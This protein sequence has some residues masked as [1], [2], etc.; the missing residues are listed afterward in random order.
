M[1]EQIFFVDSDPNHSGIHVSRPLR[2]V[3]ALLALMLLVFILQAPRTVE[4][5]EVIFTFTQGIFT[6]LIFALLTL[7]GY[8]FNEQVLGIKDR[9][10]VV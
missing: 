6:L 2:N 5:S 1:S 4:A 7:V 3:A 8:L 9:K 10:S